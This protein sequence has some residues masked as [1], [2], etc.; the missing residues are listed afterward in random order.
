MLTFYQIGQLAA[1]LDGIKAGRTAFP[2]EAL[3]EIADI[4]DMMYK[5]IQE[6]EAPK[7]EQ[8]EQGASAPLSFDQRQPSPVE[9][10]G[11]QSS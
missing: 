8:G 5:A 4:L 11:G 7:D 3:L 6:L 9:S 1:F 10:P 2:A